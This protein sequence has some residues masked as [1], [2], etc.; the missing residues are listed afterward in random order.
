MIEIDRGSY[1]H[2]A[3]YV[4]DGFVVH[5]APP[6]KFTTEVTSASLKLKDVLKSLRISC[7][8]PHLVFIVEGRGGQSTSVMSVLADRAVVKREELWDVVG[9]D[10]WKI[11]NGLDNKYE[12]RPGHIIVK[13]ACA[14]VGQL[15]PYCVL[16]DNCEHFVNE[17]RYGK[18]ESRQ[19]SAGHLQS[20][21]LCSTSEGL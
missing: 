9:T 20:L 18:A 2:W 21:L 6:C 4:G 5:L 10:N 12:P 14:L 3:V 16:R 1:Q 7:F 8:F 11:N 17:L 13:E 15:R 19:V